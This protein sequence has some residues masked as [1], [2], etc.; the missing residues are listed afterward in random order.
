M[1]KEYS[2]T[3][4]FGPG[5]KTRLEP[6][7]VTRIEILC[8]DC[9]RVEV[10]IYS[11]TSAT[12]QLFSFLDKAAAIAFCRRI[13]LLRGSQG[14]GDGQIEAKMVEDESGFD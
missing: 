14:L 7:R 2:M 9:E 3:V 4:M 1:K 12:P 13:W 10:L 5:T 6:D 11:V 8:F